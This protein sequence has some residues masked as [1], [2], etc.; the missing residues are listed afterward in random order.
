MV[1]ARFTTFRADESN[2]L[3]CNSDGILISD[4]ADGDGDL[5]RVA[6][7]SGADDIGD[8]EQAEAE[9]DEENLLGL[10]VTVTGGSALLR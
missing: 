10:D 4:A 7:N 5:G 2:S 3:G 9:S 1:V 8:D 6:S